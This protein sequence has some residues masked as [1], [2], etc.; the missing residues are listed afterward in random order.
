MRHILPALVMCFVA[1]IGSAQ[2]AD[3]L[4]PEAVLKEVRN[5]D[6]KFHKNEGEEA[7][8]DGEHLAFDQGKDEVIWV[9]TYD[10]DKITQVYEIVKDRMHVKDGVVRIPLKWLS[11]ANPAERNY[12]ADKHDCGLRVSKKD[13]KWQVSFYTID[14]KGVEVELDFISDK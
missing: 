10:E 2:A 3:E 4:K 11:M 8:S 7:T 14:T 1:L 5:L 13:G 6:L 9:R 12:N